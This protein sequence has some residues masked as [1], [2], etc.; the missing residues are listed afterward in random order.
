MENQNEQ[1]SGAHF[2][3]YAHDEYLGS[4]GGKLRGMSRE[5]RDFWFGERSTRRALKC[6]TK[7]KEVLR[8]GNHEN[9]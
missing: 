1:F 5:E 6:A 3:K 7:I 8:A 9:F 2:Q 4:D